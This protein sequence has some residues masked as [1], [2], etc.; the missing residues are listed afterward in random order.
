MYYISDL[1]IPLLIFI[2][3]I[4]IYFF[5]K[6]QGKND[7]IIYYLTFIFYAFFWNMPAILQIILSPV[8]ALIIVY[9]I[10]FKI[11][12]IQKN[13]LSYAL[14][15]HVVFFAFLM[16]TSINDEIR[17]D[18]VKNIRYQQVILKL[19]D[20]RDSQIAHRSVKGYFQNNWDSLVRF[21]ETDSFTITQRKDSSILDKEMTKRYG[22]VKTYKDIIIIDTL[23]FIQVKDSLFGFDN[24]YEQM[25][26]VP[27]A[28]DPKTKFEL[29]AGFL[30]QNGID[31]PVFEAK[32][33]KKVIL[34]DQSI[35]LVLKEN[36]VQSVDGVNGR[37]LKIGSMNEVNTNGNW[38]K[39]YSKGN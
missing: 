1:L 27:N 23:G 11:S 31:I 37:S 20:I 18:D 4:S 39:N 32:I 10:R 36:Q 35:N 6:K 33:S 28:K 5:R 25:F 24:R 34:H 9:F 13:Y 17:F 26:Y 12:T 29:N 21:I 14:L 7:N 30:N 2:I 16:F 15:A 38:P 22:G 3:L 8:F 19:K